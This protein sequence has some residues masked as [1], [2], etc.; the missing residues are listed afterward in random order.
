[1][2]R[3]LVVFD[4][5]SSSVLEMREFDDARSAL[6]ARLE[7]EAR[8]S[9]SPSVEIVVLS[10]KSKSA[11]RKTHLRYF[12]RYGAIAASALGQWASAVI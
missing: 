3:Y 5:S 2:G 11:L 1:M 6:D 7:A 9:N 10:A 8:Y 12:E 4:R